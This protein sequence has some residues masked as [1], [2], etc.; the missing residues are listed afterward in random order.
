MMHLTSTTPHPPQPAPHPL[1]ISLALQ[2]THMCISFCIKQHAIQS[3]LQFYEMF[4]HLEIG[5]KLNQ[6]WSH[7]FEVW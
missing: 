6:D 3:K 4:R 1:E 7:Q 2:T 5:S